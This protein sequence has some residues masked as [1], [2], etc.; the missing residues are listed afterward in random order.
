MS[1]KFTLPVLVLSL[2][3]L[4]FVFDSCNDPC[5]KTKCQNGGQCIE[6]LCQCP[7][8]FTGLACETIDSC[9]TQVCFHEGVCV[10]GVCDCPPEWDGVSCQTESRL[11]LLGWWAGYDECA[12][13]E[14]PQYAHEITIDSLY[15]DSLGLLWI[16]S[17]GTNM[18]NN[19]IHAFMS[20]PNE[21]TIPSQ[22]PDT[23][24]VYIE[25]TGTYDPVG[26]KLNWQ[27]TIPAVDT[28]YMCTQEAER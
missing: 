1:A 17:F 27:W 2:F 21:I 13:N 6:G 9:A 22:D 10:G 14:G 26:I 8:G 7:T 4:V 19:R 3:S 20:D 24:A 5:K 23:L 11:K 25:G 16:E 15:P 12:D 18:F 28:T